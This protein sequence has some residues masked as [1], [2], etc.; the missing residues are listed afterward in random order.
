VKTKLPLYVV[1]LTSALLLIIGSSGCGS[2]DSASFSFDPNQIISQTKLSWDAVTRDIITNNLNVDG[3]IMH[4][5]P[6]ANDLSKSFD[7]GNNTFV[8]LK[9]YLDLIPVDTRCFAVSAYTINANSTKVEGPYSDT[10]CLEY[11]G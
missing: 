1:V 11:P 3:Y 7:L 8:A 10:I 4:Y 2:S 9:D 5:G 6:S